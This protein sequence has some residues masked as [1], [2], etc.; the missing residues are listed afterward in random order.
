M[1]PSKATD[2]VYFAELFSNF[3]KMEGATSLSQFRQFWS[4][5]S[6]TDSATCF[7]TVLLVKLLAME[8]GE[9]KTQNLVEIVQKL[10]LG[11]L[12]S[13]TVDKEAVKNEDESIG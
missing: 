5:L 4:S 8:T 2:V 6:N 3:L 10:R 9:E 12:G 1:D 11:E 13:P 7:V